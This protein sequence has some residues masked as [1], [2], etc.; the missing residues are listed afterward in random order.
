MSKTQASQPSH[1]GVQYHD[2]QEQHD[3]AVA[4]MWLFLT[5]EVMFFGAAIACYALY[6]YLYPEVWRQF[7]VHL[8]VVLGTIKTAILLTSSLMVALTVHAARIGQMG[9]AARLLIS[10]AG[11]GTVFLGIKAYEWYHEY[12]LGFFPGSW[13]GNG[14]LIEKGNLYFCLYFALT[15]LHALHVLIGIGVLAVIAY[16]TWRQK[17][18][19]DYFTPIE[20][21]GLYWHFV[22]VV[23]IFLFPMLYLVDRT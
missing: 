1:L 7:S 22:D 16:F 13:Q 17:Y 5:T 20:I 14:S 23:W 19:K 18:S 15:G 21:S 3:T 8:N 9:R 6:W 10:T 2:P 11:L 4:G 12:T